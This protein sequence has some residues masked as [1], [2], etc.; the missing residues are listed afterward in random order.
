M[1]DEE[2]DTANQQSATYQPP[3]YQPAASRHEAS[4][5]LLSGC[6]VIGI[7]TASLS[8]RGRPNEVA[9]R[10]QRDQNVDKSEHLVRCL[11]RRAALIYILQNC[12]IKTP[13]GLIALLG[14]YFGS[15]D[16]IAPFFCFRSQEISEIVG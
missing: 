4:L 1:R 10:W 6:N 14:L 8:R 9:Q 7:A 11:L 12:R 3:L 15:A 5:L 13:G 2:V 16:N